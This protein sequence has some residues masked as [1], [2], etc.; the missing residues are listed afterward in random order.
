MHKHLDLPKP[1]S[2]L[3]LRR[4][5]CPIAARALELLAFT[6][7]KVEARVIAPEDRAALAAGGVDDAAIASAL[8]GRG[9]SL[10]VVPERRRAAVLDTAERALELFAMKLPPGETEGSFMRRVLQNRLA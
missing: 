3:V 6:G 5:D 2:V 1:P 10:A 8:E 4:P 7:A 9:P